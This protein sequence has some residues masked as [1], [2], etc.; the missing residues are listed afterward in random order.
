MLVDTHAIISQMDLF[1]ILQEFREKI[2][3]DLWN[4]GLV[5]GVSGGPDSLALL[6]I[7]SRFSELPSQTI[8]AHLDHKLRMIHQKT[9]NLLPKLPRVG[10]FVQLS[11]VKI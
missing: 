11:T 3:P 2:C 9:V 8:V 5:I 1:D 7:L 10:D 6:H 4:D